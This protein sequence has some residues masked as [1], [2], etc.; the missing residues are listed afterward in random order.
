MIAEKS[1]ARKFRSIQQASEEGE[2][3]NA[4]WAPGAENLADGPGKVRS[5]AAPSLRLSESGQ[6]NPGSLRPLEGVAWKE[7]A[8][9][10]KREN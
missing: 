2:L 5:D 1:L 10:G 9:H 4:D 6:F 8:D 7:R 3:T